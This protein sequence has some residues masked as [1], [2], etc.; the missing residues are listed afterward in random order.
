[1]KRV[2]ILGAGL[3]S[4]PIVDYLL[5]KPDFEV[6]V[7]SR[8]VS[9][10]EA[11]VKG[12]DHGHALAFDI[13]KNPER[14]SKLVEDSDIVVS[15][16]PYTHHIAVAGACLEHK[17]HMVTTSYVSDAMAALDARAKQQG[18]V[19]LNEMGLD[20]GIDHMSAQKIIDEVHAKDGKIVSFRSLCGGLPAPDA[21][22]NPFGYKFS[23]SPRGVV[24][25]GSNNAEF[26]EDNKEK[27]VPGAELFSS[28]F[29]FKVP[30][31]GDFEGYP[32]R[33]SLPYQNIYGIPEAKTVFR[34]TLRN[35][36]WCPTWY[37]MVRLGLNDKTERPEIADKTFAD[38][39][40][41]LLGCSAS[42][43]L[44]AKAAD[45]L[46]LNSDAKEL[47]RIEWLGYF[48]DDPLPVD[49]TSAFEV[50][51]ARLDEKMAYKD[52]ERDMIVLTHEFIAESAGGARQKIH[53]TM[54]DYGVPGG[55]SA[56]SRTVSLP[57]AIAVRMIVEGT[58]ADPGVHIPVAK[59][60]YEP[61]LAELER[62]GIVCKESVEEL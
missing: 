19:I 29:P 41:A 55:D 11:L 14:L 3:V 8:T 13:S 39:T 26:L 33:N 7:A 56:M 18:I 20:P 57:A 43:D 37:Q 46:G 61:A 4:R 35:V 52:G 48:G 24:M 27:K 58:I 36:G 62:L 60:I 25:A 54:I 16:L 2:L 9:K 53:S 15:L 23:W 49:Q 5:A 51:I 12:H 1:M 22:D 31:L 34:G 6:T 42:D 47:D 21:N 38:L 30:G 17:R 40:A 59:S 32:N 10:A 50:L 44:R 45:K 28:C